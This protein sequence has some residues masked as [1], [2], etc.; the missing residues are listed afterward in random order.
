MT[1]AFVVFI[2]LIGSLYLACC[3]HKSTEFN[4]EKTIQMASSTTLEGVVTDSTGQPLE[5]VA[6]TI[7][8]AAGEHR[9]IAAITNREGVFSF[10]DLVP[11]EYQLKFMTEHAEQTETI[12]LEPDGRRV[13]IMLR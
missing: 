10:A 3:A 5:Q 6:V 1:R 2:G 4:H 11:G 13:Q 7:A 9:D 8:K 12:T